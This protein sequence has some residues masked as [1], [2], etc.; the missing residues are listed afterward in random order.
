MNHKN[1][2]VLLIVILWLSNCLF[3]ERKGAKEYR[4]Y[5]LTLIILQIIVKTMSSE[6][7]D[8]RY[9]PTAADLF[10]AATVIQERCVEENNAFLE[11]KSKCEHPKECL[12]Q[13]HSVQDCVMDT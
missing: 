3:L 2:M 11:C 5:L 7:P 9:I 6:K 1:Y 4:D 8:L 12:A 10:A 13:A